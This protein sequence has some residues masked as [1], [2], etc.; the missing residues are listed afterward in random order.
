MKQHVIYVNGFK[1]SG[2]DTVGQILHT[3]RHAT[4]FKAA[5]PLYKAI[6]EVFSLGEGEWAA[7]YENSKEEPQE[8]LYGMTCRAAMIWLSED[9]MKPKFGDT[10]FGLSLAKRIR[11]SD[12][13]LA[14]V[15]DAG[16]LR[17]L[18]ACRNL[19]PDYQHHLIYLY[20]TGTTNEG[21]SREVIN[22]SDLG[23]DVE[24]YEPIPNNGTMEDLAKEVLSVTDYW[25]AN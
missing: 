14:V 13:E 24:H 18:E 17:E 7:M 11:D 4:L 5:T 16:Y 20:R 23:L 6:Q 1:R 22:P 9:V 12:C 2:K 19:L 8:A 25:T 10:F 21:D 3:H 15:S